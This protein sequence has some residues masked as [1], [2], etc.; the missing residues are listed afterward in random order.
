MDELLKL[1]GFG[2]PLIYAAATYGFFHWLDTNISDEARAAL[3]SMVRQTDHEDV[4]VSAA[5]LHVFDRIYPTPLLSLR[6]FARSVFFTLVV[7]AIYLYETLPRDFGPDNSLV[8][9]IVLIGISTNIFSDYFALFFIRR[10]LATR[11]QSPMLS[12]LVGFVIGVCVVVILGLI[13]RAALFNVLPIPDF[14]FLDRL[15]GEPSE[16]Q[17]VLSN[18]SSAFHFV[19][20]AFG[21]TIPATAV[22]IW[23]P[24]L[25]FGL[26]L[27]RAG[28][29]ASL[30]VAKVQ[31]LLKD[32][33]DHPLEAVGYVVGAV[34]FILAVVWQVLFKT[35]TA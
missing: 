22:F 4:K 2:A 34:V 21:L 26:L 19:F 14:S 9:N 29:P 25:A 32:G 12:L 35:A 31:W 27:L 30:V 17:M 15:N 11:F 16:I 1:L 28:T 24:L 3:A 23:L 13:R 18:I 8:L 6:T 10:W 33:K 5:I 7:S 20:G